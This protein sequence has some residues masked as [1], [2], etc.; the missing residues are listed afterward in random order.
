MIEIICTSKS[1]FKLEDNGISTHKKLTHITIAG[2]SIELPNVDGVT[3]VIIGKNMKVYFEGMKK[4]GLITE[5]I[6]SIMR[7]D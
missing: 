6:V 3:D 4:P 7:V 2:G 5:Q 1:M